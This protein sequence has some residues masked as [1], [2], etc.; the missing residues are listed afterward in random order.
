MLQVKL[1]DRTHNMRTIE[2]PPSL[3]KQQ[4]IADETLH[5]FVPI[6]KY[7]GLKQLEE[8][9]QEITVSVLKKR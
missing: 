3:A 5:F 2:G 8:E 1:A 4:Q 7:L 6:A 9:L